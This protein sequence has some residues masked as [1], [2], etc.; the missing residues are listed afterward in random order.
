MPKAAKQ[1]K[2][3]PEELL[4]AFIRSNNPKLKEERKNYAA[5]PNTK[6]I[7]N[8]NNQRRRTT[9]S[10]ILS[11]LKNSTLEDEEGN[12]YCVK[13]NRLVKFSKNNKQKYVI[14]CNKKGELF[15]F[16]FTKDEELEDPKFDQPLS[17]PQSLDA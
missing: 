6:Q 14:R 5:D 10:S 12:R 2:K 13:S 8:K 1:K 3:K 7:R 16:Q 9:C 11:I 15:E 17:Q 4:K